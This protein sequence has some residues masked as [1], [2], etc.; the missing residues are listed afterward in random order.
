MK[1]IYKWL[2]L[3]TLTSL[4][5]VAAAQD[6]PGLSAYR[7]ENKKIIDSPHVVN[8]VYIG[9]SITDRWISASPEFFSGNHFVDRG[10]GGQTSPQIL[11][12]FRQD[13]I[14]LHP[15]IAVLLCG[16]NDLAGNTGPSSLKMICDNIQ[17]MAELAKANN[18]KMI[19]CSVL[20][21]DHFPWKPE[22][23]PAADIVRLN[24]WIKDYAK[25]SHLPYVDYYSAMVNEQG[26]LKNEYSPDG[27]HPN[28]DGYTVMEGLVLK[29]IM[30]E[31]QLNRSDK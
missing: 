6:W 25:K 23:K 14:D 9:D 28:K 15:K 30:I 26:G 5:A 31:R 19:L 2:I 22:L 27:V 3:L 7:D 16:T 13:V 21:A 24:S 4:S 29:A 20:P 8:A 1:H 11:L 17:S 12:R 18:I 10:I